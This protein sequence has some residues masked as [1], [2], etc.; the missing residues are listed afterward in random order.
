MNIIKYVLYFS[1]I[2]IVAGFLGHSIVLIDGAK[3]VLKLGLFTLLI[4]SLIYFILSLIKKKE[5]I[6]SGMIT[7][8]GLLI[9]GVF[10]KLMNYPGGGVFVIVGS[11]IILMGAIGILIYSL[12]KKR[13]VEIP[14]AYLAVGICAL[15]FVFKVQ[16]WPEFVMLIGTTAL[17]ILVGTVF[18][19]KQKKILVPS[20]IV[21]LI[22][23]GFTISLIFT[24]QSQVFRFKQIE[25]NQSETNPEFFHNYSWE[26]YNEHKFDEAS[27]NIDKAIY[28]VSNEDNSTHYRISDIQQLWLERY[29]RAKEKIKNQNW[30]EI[31]RPKAF[32]NYN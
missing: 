2:L 4:F 21:I 30:N 3:G 29:L 27:I 23:Y 10:F 9:L 19:F 16:Y 14:V 7:L 25:I 18:I 26:L 17:S 5:R 22:I 12:T 32:P 28:E 15:F 11:Q 20:S 24:S 13:N 6:A 31:E 8:S 1:F